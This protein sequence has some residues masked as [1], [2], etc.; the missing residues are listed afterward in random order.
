M[1]SKVQ[2][3][4]A[5]D[6]AHGDRRGNRG[7]RGR[8][9]S[10]RRPEPIC[11]GDTAREPAVPM[12]RRMST[13]SPRASDVRTS[14]ATAGPACCMIDPRIRRTAANGYDRPISRPFAATVWNRPRATSVATASRRDLP[15]PGSPLRNSAPPPPDAARSRV[16]A[17]GDPGPAPPS[18]GRPSRRRRAGTGSAPAIVT[19]SRR[20]SAARP[21]KRPTLRRAPTAQAVRAPGRTFSTRLSTA[22]RAFRRRAAGGSPGSS[23]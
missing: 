20:G 23:D 5:L 3:L 10:G 4:V 7:P 21:R 13:S 8:G 18:R 6:R 19:A 1:G 12:P 17:T 9:P 22:P 16:R 11:G 14:S 15:R 2:V